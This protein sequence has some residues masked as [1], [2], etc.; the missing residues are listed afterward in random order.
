MSPTTASSCLPSGPRAL[1]ALFIYGV[2]LSSASALLTRLLPFLFP[3][4]PLLLA[5]YILATPQ[6]AASQPEGSGSEGAPFPVNPPRRA[7]LLPPPTAP[8]P[9]PARHHHRD[10]LYRGPALAVA[11]FPPHL[12]TA[13]ECNDAGTKGKLVGAAWPLSRGRTSRHWRQ[14]Y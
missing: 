1:L 6:S 2:F 7:P 12:N 4:S 3:L 9:R 13:P 10:Q 14:Q 11:F 8:W 5:A